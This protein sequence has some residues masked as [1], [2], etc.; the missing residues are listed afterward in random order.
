MYLERFRR[1][2]PSA[3][4]PQGGWTLAEQR[5]QVA[6]LPL[7]EILASH[8]TFRHEGSIRLEPDG[9]VDV[10]WI[11]GYRDGQDVGHILRFEFDRD[12]TRVEI[13]WYEIPKDVPGPR[14][15]THAEIVSRALFRV[16][17]FVALGSP[18]HTQIDL[19]LARKHW[20][21]LSSDD[22]KNFSWDP[23]AQKL[24][25]DYEFDGALDLFGPEKPRMMSSDGAIEAY[26]L[27]HSH[28]VES[29]YL[30]A[31]PGGVVRVSGLAPTEEAKRAVVDA[32]TRDGYAI[33]D[34]LSVATH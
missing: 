5:K 1:E 20:A 22:R 6:W 7:H 29:P 3:R 17:R 34:L 19:E 16:S 12:T 30:E 27:L 28:Q 23:S 21:A 10:P 2:P 9:F 11:T 14:P 4:A 33:E 13:R 18:E 31:V 25:R 15:Y 32:L 24:L 26:A 8:G